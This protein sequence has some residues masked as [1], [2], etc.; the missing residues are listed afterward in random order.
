MD[1]P[2]S[3]ID[4]AI[5]TPSNEATTIEAIENIIFLFV[6]KGL[7]TRNKVA[8]PNNVIVAVIIAFNCK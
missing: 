8:K 5:S 4:N 7:Q 6:S 2:L 1:S 3:K